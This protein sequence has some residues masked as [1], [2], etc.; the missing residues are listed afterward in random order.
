ML[1]LPV[2]CPIFFNPPSILPSFFLSFFLS[3]CDLCPTSP[4]HAHGLTAC[5]K[6]GLGSQV[7]NRHLA[8]GSRVLWDV[9][10]SVACLV[11]LQM[12]SGSLATSSPQTA[13]VYQ[14][15]DTIFNGGYDKVT[16]RLGNSLNLASQTCPS[17][18]LSERV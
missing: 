6:F 5:F 3:F 9:C 16:S 15:L 18:V 4:T 2:L 12:Y 8:K 1:P 11:C 7:F 13:F 10:I 14:T 17:P